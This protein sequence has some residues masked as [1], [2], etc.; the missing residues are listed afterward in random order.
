MSDEAKTPEVLAEDD[1]R[2]VDLEAL[3]KELKEFSGGLAYDQARIIERTQDGFKQGVQGFYL[4]GLGLILMDRHEGATTL[5]QILDQ[6]FPGINR[7]S[8]ER[9]MQFVR[10]ASKLPNFKQFC[11]ERGGYSK[12]LTMLQA[13]T[14]AEIEQFADT[15]EV[16][17]YSME[18]ISH[19]SVRT[20]QKALFKAKE[21]AAQAVEKAVDKTLAE[22][23]KLRE[24]NDALKAA[25]TE[26]DVQVAFKIIREAEKKFMEGAA[27]LRKITPELLEREETV[28][29]LVFASSGMLGRL[30]TQM[31]YT[32][33]EALNRVQ[34][35]E[36]EGDE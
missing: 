29:N 32:A 6:Y 17:G 18:E 14:E 21:K 31:E 25:M 3:E 9:Y 27:L 28:R 11:L 10:A 35:A 24:E 16:R 7:R 12:G 8:A 23:V 30:T 22:N 13:C 36:G 4:A 34:A 20:L 15:G 2:V 5:S 26:P 1:Q 33:Q 19:M